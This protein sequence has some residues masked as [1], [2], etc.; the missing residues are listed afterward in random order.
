MRKLILALLALAVVSAPLYASNDFAKKSKSSAASTEAPATAP[1][2]KPS[3]PAKMDDQKKKIEELKKELNGS[4][5]E[6]QM[7]SGGKPLGKDTFTFQNGQV[8]CKTLADKGY[9]P[10]NYTISMPEGADMA[11]WETMQTGSKGQVVFIR[12]E[13]KEG[14]M[15]GV[16]SEQLE[17]NKTKDYN[18]ASLSKV[19]VPA[20][21]EKKEEEK[22]ATPAAA[23]EG[24]ALVSKSRGVSAAVA[25][26]EPGSTNEIKAEKTKKA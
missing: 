7:S 18:F 12:A 16:M 15:R 25:P 24:S 11:T 8:T 3:R 5:W 22:P 9:S 1:A 26:F 4:Q 13:W 6:V 21:T 14:V 17:E 2:A 19:E 10:T 20:T 23:P